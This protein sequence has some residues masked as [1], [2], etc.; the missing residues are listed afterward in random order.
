MK[1]VIFDMDGTLFQ[2]DR[3]LETSLED[4]FEQLRLQGEWE[5]ETPLQLYR[6]IMGVPLPKVWE[7]L[8]PDCS[9]ATRMYSDQ[10]FLERLIR[11]IG[12]GLGALYP[13]AL[14][15]LEKLKANDIQIFVASNGLK[16]YLESIVSHFA[17]DRFV[18][19]TYS[20]EQIE[21]LSKSDLVKTI[22]KEHFV[23]QAIM[24]GDRMSDIQAA[25]D[26]NLLSIGC[27]FDFAQEG[28]L[29]FADVVIE[30]LSEV[31]QIVTHHFQY[32]PLS[33]YSKEEG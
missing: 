25:K 18:A 33:A 14:D 23:T 12:E 32:Q 2:T 6:D 20:I 15:V 26:N 11:N 9:G 8:L 28:E 7:T 16:K 30:D 27:R 24:I 1:A 29:Q 31:P 17:L 3:I 10:Y 4:T 19:G 21:S 13:N 22:L 5:G